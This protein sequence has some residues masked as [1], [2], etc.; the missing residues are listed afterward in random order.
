MSGVGGF[1]RHGS[2]SKGL[3]SGLM[4]YAGGQ[5]ARYWWSRFTRSFL[6]RRINPEVLK[7]LKTIF[8]KPI[9]LVQDIFSKTGLKKIFS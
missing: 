6:L 9:N 1:D 2:I 5:A 7:E 4:N 3:K 8:S